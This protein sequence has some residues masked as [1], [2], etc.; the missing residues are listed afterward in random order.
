VANNEI[1]GWFEIKVHRVDVWFDV[2]FLSDLG[3]KQIGRLMGKDDGIERWRLNFE[4]STR[5]AF[6]VLRF[7]M[8]NQWRS[9][10][11]A[12][13]FMKSYSQTLPRN[14]ACCC[15]SHRNSTIHFHCVKPFSSTASVFTTFPFQRFPPSILPTVKS[16]SPKS[17]II[18]SSKS[19]EFL[20]YRLMQWPGTVWRDVNKEHVAK[21]TKEFFLFVSHGHICRTD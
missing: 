13:H 4:Q 6:R 9:C 21:R 15:N 2:A 5:G 16:F 17:C 11:F 14:R 3:G 1:E 8:L 7:Q 18:F 19:R 12:K 10:R 20:P